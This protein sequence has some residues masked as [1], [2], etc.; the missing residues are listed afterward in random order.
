ME[1]LADPR[2]GCSKETGGRGA[3][4]IDIDESDV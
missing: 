2:Y 1:L 4:V 3:E